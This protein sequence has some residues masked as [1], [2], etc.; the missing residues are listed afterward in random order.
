MAVK[1]KA[2]AA[3]PKIQSKAKE[4]EKKS[5]EAQGAEND[6]YVAAI[7][8]LWILCFVPLFLKKKSKFAQHH[9]K[10]GLVLFIAEI[11]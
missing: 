4:T 2:K 8:Y 1:T 7:S 5:K 6:K 10:Q 9:A 11:L 3:K